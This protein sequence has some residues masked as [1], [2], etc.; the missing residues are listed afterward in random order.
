M[1]SKTEP[2]VAPARDVV[3][4]VDGSAASLDALRWA[5]GEA[6]RLGTGVDVVRVEHGHVVESLVAAQGPAAV[7]E[8]GDL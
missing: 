5:R 2:C 7:I 1:M 4:G 6:R 8:E 3:V